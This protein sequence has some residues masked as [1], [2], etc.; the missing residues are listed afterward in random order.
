MDNYPWF[1]NYDEGVPRTLMPYPGTTMIEVV[2]E[3][4]KAKPYRAMFYFK[5]HRL[6]Y[7]DFVRQSDALAAGLVALGIKK[8]ERVALLLPNS[9]QM[10]LAFQGIWKAGAIAVPINPLYT[11]HELK[12]AL[13]E[14]DAS[15]VIVLNPFYQ[16]VKNIQ[17]DTTIRTVIATSIKEYLPAHLGLLFTLAREKKEGYRISL[18]KGDVW[19][20]ELLRQHKNDPRPDIEVR[21]E[22]AAVILFSGGTT[23]TPKGAV[24]THGALIMTAMQINAW[25]GPVLE[26][27]EDRVALTMPLFHVF[28]CAGALGTAM[29]NR[30]SCI[31]IPNPRDVTDVVKSIQKYKPAFMP[32][33][34]TFYI[35]IM[36]HPLVKSGKV[37]LS[38]M[39]ICIVGAAPLM[40]D[41]KKQFE[42]MTGGRL[43]EG[44][45]MT[46][47][48]QAATLNP[49][50]GVNK[51]G[52]VG[53]PLPDVVIKIVDSETGR[54]DMK[55]GELGEICFKAPNLM[56]G[57]WKRPQETADMLRDG[58][59][60]T[61]DIGYLDNDGHLFLHS[62]KKDIIKT[63]G[64][65]VWP[66]EVEEILHE[67]PAVMEASVAGVPDQYQGEAV[68]AWVVLNAGMTCTAE[69]LREHCKSKLSAYK[70]PRYIEFKTNLPKTQIGKI[71]RRVLIEEETSK[72]GGETNHT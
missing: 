50:M 27:W 69:E 12:H 43:L 46:E 45:A 2:D 31:L 37:K 20:Q 68:K 35:A 26:K 30:S 53:M 15:A 23:G 24:G 48:M 55:A 17:A 5:G 13:T 71:L 54:G 51:E 42:N 10:V 49:I 63:S 32:G 58:W 9:P 47:T 70:V 40:A 16:A 72:Q 3:S 4:A 44:Y 60:Y 52:S 56:A 57:Y 8:G 65:Q 6:L 29:I 28:G 33:V 21:P 19:F 61:G 7:H 14:V 66:R 64:F 62:R 22:D 1:K 34:P 25:L 11:E 59:L 39:K 67:H 36:N 41:T 18:Q 38:G